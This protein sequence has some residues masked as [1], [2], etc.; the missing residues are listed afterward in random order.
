MGGFLNDYIGFFMLVACRRTG[1]GGGSGTSS[2]TGGV[3]RIASGKAPP[4]CLEYSGVL[5]RTETKVSHEGNGE[6]GK[7]KSR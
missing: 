5:L 6:P 1:A 3:R 2:S 4:I 7:K